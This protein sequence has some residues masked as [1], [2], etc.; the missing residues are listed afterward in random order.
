[1]EEN[2]DNDK[3][4]LSRHK[5]KEEVCKSPQ[6]E[7]ERKENSEAQSTEGLPD[8]SKNKKRKRT[9]SI[10]I[11]IDRPYDLLGI[12]NEK[13]EEV[14]HIIPTPSIPENDGVHRQIENEG[15]GG[16]YSG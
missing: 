1:M 6:K 13:L 14:L 5:S 7:E 15:G 10:D 16:T 3:S 8:S 9:A 11:D 12:A 4:T 2:Q